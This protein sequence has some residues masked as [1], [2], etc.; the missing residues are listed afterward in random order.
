MVEPMFDGWPEDD[1]E[2]L[3]AAELDERGRAL[4]AEADDVNAVIGRAQRRFL[5]LVAEIDRTQVWRA[6]GAR[7]TAHWLGMR[8]GISSWKAH[9]W[10][11][12]A[13][14]LGSLVRIA[15]ALERGELG[16]DKVVELA[17]FATPQ[18]EARL[19]HWARE[20]SCG[21]VRRRAELLAEAERDE[22]ERP[23][24]NRSLDWWFSD[25]G[26]TMFLEGELPAAQG[27]VVARTLDRMARTVPAMP[28]EDDACFASARRADALV[29]LCS[30]PDWRGTPTP[31]ARPS[32]STRG[33]RRSSATR[34]AARSRTAR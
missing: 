25:E 20:V 10:V 8:Y 16:I 11:G 14:A 5:G 30:R 21:A 13:H 31:I 27:A 15:A 32:S 2:D 33:S 12:A 1:C 24:R 22:V 7:D 34:G 28:G 6:D 23:E 19:V 3:A 4:V 29:A 9:R 18:T 17:R 26:R